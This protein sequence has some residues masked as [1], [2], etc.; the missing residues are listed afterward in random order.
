MILKV[1]KLGSGYGPVTVLRDVSFTQQTG[2]ILGVVGHNGM[3]KTTLLRTLI[4]VLRT[5]TG[6]ITFRDQPVT[7]VSAHRRSH[8]GIGYVPQGDRGF[9]NL[10]VLENLKIA[11]VVAG[12]NPNTPLDDVLALFPRLEPLLNRQSV[13]LSGGERQLL[14]IARAIVRSPHLLLLDEMTEGVQPSIVDEIAQRL[15]LLHQQRKMS[16]LIVDQ[17]LAFVASLCTRAL[18]MQKGTILK[19][20]NSTQLITE[21]VLGG[22]VTA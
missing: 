10:T 16:I 13:A 9:P 3:G 14:A 6:A 11:A 12:A 1:D 8:L 4:G 15:R 17:D 2:E 18:V 7:R 5:D 19:A 21:N 22:F 20:V